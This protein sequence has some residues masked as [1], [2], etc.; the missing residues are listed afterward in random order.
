MYRLDHEYPMKPEDSPLLTKRPSE[1]VREN[2][3]F[4]SQP[5]EGIDHP[6]YVCNT[7]RAFGGTENLLFASD[8]PHHDFDNS[9]ELL[10]ALKTSFTD[11]E[12]EAIYGGNAR[13]VY[14]V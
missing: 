12:I 13:E 10:R 6:E 14:S 11:D 2:F 4:T 8:Y 3:Y 7:I 5:V 9:N 1:Y